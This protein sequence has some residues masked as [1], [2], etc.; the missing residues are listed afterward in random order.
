MAFDRTKLSGNIG[1]GSGAPK[2]FTYRTDDA[3]ADV[4][5]DDYFAGAANILELGDFIYA[6]TDEDGTTAHVAVALVVTKVVT[7]PGSE[8]VDTAYVAVA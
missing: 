5:A 1:A 7:T 2:F 8:E 6:S 3:T 4:I